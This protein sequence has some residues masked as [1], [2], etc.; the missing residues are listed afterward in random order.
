MYLI[1]LPLFDLLEPKFELNY[2]ERLDLIKK[3]LSFKSCSR[4]TKL[5]YALLLLEIIASFGFVYLKYHVSVGDDSSWNVEKLLFL[6]PFGFIL[7]YFPLSMCFY[8]FLDTENYRDRRRRD[9]ENL[10]QESVE[11]MENN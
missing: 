6:H 5:C 9:L 10:Y 1:L 8:E 2:A 7:F 11:R 3:S 4:N